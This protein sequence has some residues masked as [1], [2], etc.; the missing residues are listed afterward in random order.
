MGPGS[1][2]RTN[3]YSPGRSQ[4]G[5]R[6]SCSS[7]RRMRRRISSSGWSAFPETSSRSSMESC[8]STISSRRSRPWTQGKR[9]GET[10]K[11]SGTNPWFST[12]SWGPLR[13]GCSI[14]RTSPKRTS[15]RSWYPRTLCSSWATTATTAR[16]AASGG[17]SS[18]KRSSAGP[19]SSTGPGT[20]TDAG[21]GGSGSEISFTKRPEGLMNILFGNK[22][23]SRFA[24]FFWLLLLFIV[25]HIAVKLVPMYMDYWRMDDEI[26]AKAGAAQ[27]FKD[28]E[29]TYSL[30]KKAKELALPL[31][32][33]N[34]ILLR[35]LRLALYQD[36]SFPAQ[37]R[38][39][40]YH[41]GQI[42][43]AACRAGAGERG[44][45]RC[46]PCRKGPAQR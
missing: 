35:D 28:D 39:E 46:H 20:A 31:G 17:S 25:V 22:G 3:G 40:L 19:S 7:T 23:A 14:S 4:G 18:S 42:T 16:T 38:R 44:K 29:I 12:N 30:E 32:R 43:A 24:V 8:T 21:F 6:L 10:R 37:R 36:I 11:R 1:P 15:V 45:H 13:T 2:S 41:P 27:V 5:E 33:E 26:R 9:R 34:F